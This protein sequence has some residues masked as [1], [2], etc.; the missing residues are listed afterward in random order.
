MKIIYNS[1]SKSLKLANIFQG[2][3]KS[4]YSFVVLSLILANLILP[5]HFA[6]AD[7]NNTPIDSL[8]MASS[9]AEIYSQKV[10]KLF[11]STLFSFKDTDKNDSHLPESNDLEVD[12]S[13]TITITA[14]TSEV[15]QCDDS[16][17][18]TAN[19]FNVCKNAKEDTIAINGLKFGTKI[20][21]PDL[22]GDR[23]FVVRDR[24]N[25]RYKSNRGDIWMVEKDDA[26]KFGVQIARVEILK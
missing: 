25:A 11:S 14:Y 1:Y 22:F 7:S 9:T 17:C 16:P 20:R 24:M 23:V 4:I 2:L 15:G 10:A 13:T 8:K 3:E 18:I 26:V 12:H 5:S 21:I 19:G 6:L